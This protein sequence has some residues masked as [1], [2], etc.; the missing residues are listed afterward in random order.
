[1]GAGGKKAAI[2]GVSSILLVAM[3]VAAVVVGN[4]RNTQGSGAGSPTG[5]GKVTAT[6]KAIKAICQPTDYKETCEESLS[7]ANSTDPKELVKVGFQVAVKNIGDVMKNSTLLQ[8]AAKDPTIKDAYENCHELL[9]YSIADLQRSFDKVG[10]FDASKLD[11]YLADIKTWLSGAI[12]YQQTCLDGFENTT[13]DA[14]EKMKSLLKTAGEISSNGLAMVTQFSTILRDLQIPGLSR[15]LLSADGFPSWVSEGGRKLLQATPG[16]IKPNVVVA[17]DGSGKYKTITEALDDIPVKSNSTFIIY[18]KAGI[19][20]ESVE[21]SKS[22]RFVMLIGDGPTKTKITASKSKVGGSSTYKSATFAANGDGFIAKDIGFENSAGS[23]MHQAVALRVS[24][25]RSIIYNCQID[26]YQDTL[27]AHVHR[28]FYRDCTISGTID[29][30][31]GDAASVF[32]NCKMVVRKP[33]DN[34]MCM[35]TAQ[36]RK[37]HFE[38]TAIVLQNC[39]ITAEPDVLAA[40]PPVRIFLGRPWKPFSRTIIMNSQIDSIIDPQGWYEW[41][42]T[43]HLDTLYY[44]EYNNRGPGSVQTKRVTWKGLKKLTPDE[45]ANYT[46]GKLLLGDDWI[47]ATGV[48]YESGMINA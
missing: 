16:T 7:S 44:G 33:M 21:L 28:Q 19:Y 31:F 15:R 24:S 10:A 38:T 22:M 39:T 3:V 2:L 9:D 29:F 42:G 8:Q 37:E 6:T 34:Q 17:K 36:G 1:M 41:A 12:T 27:Y 25:D 35:V 26:G 14:G 20:E 45:A 5:N 32:Q 30:I 23:E 47:P 11:S 18:V 4:Y 43:I 46:P 48:P 13:S 40:K